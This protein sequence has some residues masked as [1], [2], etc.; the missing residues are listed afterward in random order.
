MEEWMDV[1]QEANDLTC[2][3]NIKLFIDDSL[4]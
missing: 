4:E 2:R 1:H 3:L